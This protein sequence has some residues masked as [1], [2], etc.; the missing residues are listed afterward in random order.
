M[1]NMSG[2]LFVKEVFSI[3]YKTVNENDPLSKCWNLFKT[4]K[5]PVLAVVNEKN[6]Y[7]GIITRKCGASGLRQSFHKYPQAGIP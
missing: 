1:N 3:N 4:E 7:I 2:N 6:R 5:S